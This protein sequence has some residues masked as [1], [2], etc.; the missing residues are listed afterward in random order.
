MEEETEYF[1]QA[2]K[3]KNLTTRL[4][5][6]CRSIVKCFVPSSSNKQWRHGARIHANALH[7]V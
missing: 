1:K 6:K 4:D 3:V 2:N 7:I 5:S